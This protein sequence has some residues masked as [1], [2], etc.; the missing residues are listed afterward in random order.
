M[1]KNPKKLPKFLLYDG[2]AKSGDTE[3]AWVMDTAM[4][5]DEARREGNTT[6]KGHDAIWEEVREVEPGVVEAVRL[7]WDL[8][9][10]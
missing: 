3:N 4:T 10:A 9:P 6:W 2:R 7:R 1:S 5:E 8:P